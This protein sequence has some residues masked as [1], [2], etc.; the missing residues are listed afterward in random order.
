MS[1]KKP[2]KTTPKFSLSVIIEIVSHLKELKKHR[3]MISTIL[4]AFVSL[5]S[6]EPYFY[7]WLIWAIE[8][9]SDISEIFTI[10][11]LWAIVSISAILTSYYYRIKLLDYTMI[12][13]RNFLL[14]IM[15]KMQTLPI[16]YHRNIQAGEKQKIVDRSAEA[17]WEMWDNLILAVLPQILIF[18]IL[19]IGWMIID[20]LFTFLSLIFLPIG[21]G[22]VVYF[23]RKANI[24]QSKVNPLW[25]KVFDRLS[26][27]ITNLPVIRI[28]SRNA[29]ETGEM[30]G[31]LDKAIDTQYAVRKDWSRFN[32]FGRLFTLIAKLITMTAGWILLYQWKTD[33]ATFFFFIAFTDRIY[34]PIMELFGV[35][36][37]TVK[38]TSY[39]HKAKELLLMD[40]EKDSWTK[41][42]FKV[43]KFITFKNL[44]FSYPSS[45][46]EVLSDIE[47]EIK[48]WERIALIWHTG[49]GKSTIIQLLMRFYEPTS[50]AIEIDGTD[51]Y[52]FTLDSYR[53]KFAAVFQDTTLFNETIRHNLE[54][55]RD[56][57][58]DAKLKKA[59]KEANILE[60]IESLPEAWETQVG[61]RGLKLSGGEKQRIAIARAILADPEI[62]ILDEATSAL[63]TKTEKL[64][65]SAFDH[66]M[67]SR[68]SIIIAHRL[69]T[70]MSADTIYLMEKGRIVAKWS[71][72]ELYKISPEY[73]EMVDLQHDGFVGEEAEEEI[74]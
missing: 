62:L 47:F 28:F 22:G 37:S 24:N 53:S 46:R 38:N 8:K 30:A 60:F 52:D 51:I 56:G 31:R 73:K 57:I 7:K 44:S 33:Y 15:T 21:I 3:I 70:I 67:D 72:T 12:D 9:K 14:H 20:P 1:D 61:E 65:Q 6:M 49:S 26:D 2:E 18:F 27:S 4:L 23:G 36:Q 69:S 54:Y 39:Y 35:V 74:V 40:S 68:T 48:K 63:D 64:V 11:I 42:L 29:H 10:I 59:C 45:P 19:L 71:H 41:I 66:L 16:E 5:V 58:T 32:S 50:G 34:S 43:K 55:V 17:V 13:W 25:D